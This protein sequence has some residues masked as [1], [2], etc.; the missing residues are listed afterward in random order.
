MMMMVAVGE[1]SRQSQLSGGQNQSCF[2]LVKR[3]AINKH[4]LGERSPNL[5]RLSGTLRED[6]FCTP[7]FDSHFFQGRKRG[8]MVK[9]KCISILGFSDLLMLL[10]LFRLQCQKQKVR[11]KGSRFSFHSSSPC[12]DMNCHRICISL[13][14]GFWLEFS[15]RQ[16]YISSRMFTKNGAR[17]PLNSRPII[18]TAGFFLLSVLVFVTP[19]MALIFMTFTAS[20][21]WRNYSILS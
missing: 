2:V 16:R 4:H 15:A 3:G 13:M 20:R 12:L 11:S 7:T 21:K 1:R 9:N 10:L 6:C 19:I 8:I 18:Q 14:D 17:V 5:P